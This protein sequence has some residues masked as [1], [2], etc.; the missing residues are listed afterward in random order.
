MKDPRYESKAFLRI[1]ECYV[2]NAIGQL[3]KGDHDRLVEMTPMLQE[4]FN[5]QGEWVSIVDQVMEFPCGMQAEINKIWDKN[6]LIANETN[7]VLTPEFFAKMFVD[8]NF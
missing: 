8:I 3:E 1:L 5:V 2:L 4:T 6:I 7:E